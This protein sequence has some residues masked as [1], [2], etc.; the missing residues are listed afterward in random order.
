MP[1]KR[2]QQVSQAPTRPAAKSGEA[3]FDVADLYAGP[4]TVEPSAAASNVPLDEKLR[5]AYFWITNHAVINPFYD[6]EYNDAPPQKLAFG[7][8]G[9]EVALPTDQ[10]YSSY[11]LLPL[12]NLA[13]RRRCLLVGGPGRGK[14][15]WSRSST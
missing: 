12:L 3:R 11:V 8:Q 4:A 6:V 10:S 7:D 14:T 1:R 2:T 5:Q 15:R 9:V 13:V